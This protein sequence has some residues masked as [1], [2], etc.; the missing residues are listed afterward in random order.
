MPQKYS[1]TFHFD[2]RGH[3]DLVLRQ[4]GEAVREWACRSGSINRDGTLVNCIPVGMWKI[5]DQPVWTNEPE[6]MIGGIGWKA[7]LYTAEGQFTHYLVHP[8]GGLPGSKGCIVTIG[9]AATALKERIEQMLKEQ[10]VILV[11]VA[12]SMTA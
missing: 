4:D 5:L 1:F 12:R 6:M 3:G 9:T 11:E 10:Q 8:D 7:R 2:R